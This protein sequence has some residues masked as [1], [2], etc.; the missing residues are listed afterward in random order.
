MESYHDMQPP[1]TPPL[2]TYFVKR[3]GEEEIGPLSLAQL[4]RMRSMGQLAAND[5]CR[6]SDG[7]EYQPLAAMFPHLGEHERKSAEE[8]RQAAR[9]VEG[10]GIANAALVCSALSW[11]IATPILSLFGIVLGTKSYIFAHRQTGLYAVMIG[12]LSLMFWGARFFGF[13]PVSE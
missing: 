7:T 3:G 10:N 11:V 9:V 12:V 1:T 4:N 6:C 13:V 2:K 8:H 5:L